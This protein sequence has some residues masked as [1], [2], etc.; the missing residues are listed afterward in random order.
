MP[1]V[2][3]VVFE[4]T[5]D[6]TN[7]PDGT[8]AL[9]GLFDEGLLE[10]G[11]H[12]YLSGASI[13]VNRRSGGT[14]L[15]VGPTDG[16]K[17]GELIQ[18]FVDLPYEDNKILNVKFTIDGSADPLSCAVGAMGDAAGCM[19][20]DFNGHTRS[21]SYGDVKSYAA[22]EPLPASYTHTEFANGAYP[23]WDNSGLAA[24]AAYN[25]VLDGCEAAPDPVVE[26]TPVD[27]DDMVCYDGDTTLNI[28]FSNVAGLYGY[29][30]KVNYDATKWLPFS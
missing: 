19:T 25:L 1:E 14:I 28:D 17:G 3:P 10:A 26:P 7:I 5:I 29:E 2:E 23:G 18:T 15:R 24:N 6:A 12:G 22:M 30:F 16:N 20:L 8:T 4:G 11:K 9:I 27:G 21:D 13:Y